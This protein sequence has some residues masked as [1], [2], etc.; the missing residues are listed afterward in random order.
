[1]G[2]TVSMQRR[3]LSIAILLTAAVALGACGS[4][5]PEISVT[6]LTTTTSVDAIAAPDDDGATTTTA[7]DTTTTSTTTTTTTTIPPG[8]IANATVEFEALARFNQPIDAVVAPNGEWWLAERPGRIVVVDPDTGVAGDVVADL[9]GSTQAGGERGLLGIAV[10]SDALYANYTDSAGTT[11]IAAF[12][13]DS[14]G[15]PGEAVSLLSIAQPFSN[16]NGGSLAI[17]P[18]GH[19]YIGVG[20]G[21]SAGDPLNAG[22]DADQLLGS[23]LRIEP[24]PSD[25]DPYAI[26]AD[27][28]FADG[29]G[30]PEVFA[31]GLRN[32]WRMSFDPETNDLWVADVGQDS[33]EEI[34][35]LSG[36][37]GWGRGANLGWRLREGFEAYGGS[38]PDNNVDPV[39][40]YRHGGSPTGCS[41]TGG[42][43]YRGDEVADL[44]GA[45]LFGDYCTSRLWAVTIVDG[46]AVFADLDASIPGGEFVNMS[47]MPNGEVAVFS[48]GGQVSVL[49]AASG[50]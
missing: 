13:L 15:R 29:G 24:T 14:D 22:Q 16:H 4:D 2:K 12:P 30:Q 8:N 27:N 36:D 50:S 47:V 18:D 41:I 3:G 35:V 7:D 32:P 39:F 10:D 1:M 20:D 38:R 23:I 31:L 46:E 48:L 26:P 49:R 25:D 5:E 21:G 17:G 40:T 33:Y 19:L 45:Y 28:P 11:Q 37:S 9:T 44:Y 42:E 34:T 6:Q 43:M